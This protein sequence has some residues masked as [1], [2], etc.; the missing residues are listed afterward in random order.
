MIIQR[1]LFGDSEN[2]LKVNHKIT[3][4]FSYPFPS[5]E[6]QHQNLVH[7]SI[8]FGKGTQCAATDDQVLGVASYLLEHVK[9]FAWLGFLL[10]AKCLA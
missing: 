2:Y 3:P 10:N 6:S 9:K 7:A 8:S 5:M 1:Q 4:V